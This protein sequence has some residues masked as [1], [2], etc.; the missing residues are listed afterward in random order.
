MVYKDFLHPLITFQVPLLCPLYNNKIIYFVSY[1]NIQTSIIDTKI[2]FNN[3]YRA[4]SALILSSQDDSPQKGDNSKF[5]LLSS[6][7]NSFQLS[8]RLM[9]SFNS[10]LALLKITLFVY[11]SELNKMRYNK[12]ITLT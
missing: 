2:Y 4:L 1:K 5:F 8:A 12:S 6:T 7:Q 10:F 3:I 9:C 11:N